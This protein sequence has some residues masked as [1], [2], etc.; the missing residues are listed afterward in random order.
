[1]GF[2]KE[3]EGVDFI[4]RSKPLSDKERSAISEFII[5]YKAKNTAPKTSKLKRAT[6][7]TKTAK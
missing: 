6:V 7:I 1:M 5:N 3:P 4:I 2:I